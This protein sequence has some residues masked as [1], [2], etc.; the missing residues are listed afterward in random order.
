MSATDI[1]KE[2]VSDMGMGTLYLVL[3]A[4]NP[5]H[6]LSDHAKSEPIWR[7]CPRYVYSVASQ[8]LKV[9]LSHRPHFGWRRSNAAQFR[10]DAQTTGDLAEER[11]DGCYREGRHL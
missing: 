5:G 6:I 3:R 7:S 8:T 10:A 1:I 9:I 2:D 4:T 11:T